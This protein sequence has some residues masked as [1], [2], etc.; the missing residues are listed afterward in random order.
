[1]Q[2]GKLILRSLRLGNNIKT[3]RYL[4]SPPRK[5]YGANH[6]PLSLAWNNKVPSTAKAFSAIILSALSVIN[7]H[8]DILFTIGPP[9]LLSG[10]YTYTRRDKHLFKKEISKILPNGKLA[11]EQSGRLYIKKYDESDVKNLKR[12]V[13]SVFDNFKVQILELAERRILD[14]ISSNLEEVK[15]KLP[16]IIDENDQITAKLGSDSIETFISLKVEILH[17][18]SDA[19]ELHS[20]IKLSVPLYLNQKLEKRHRIGV[21]EISLIEIGSPDQIDRLAYKYLIELSP[22]KWIVS[23]KDKIKIDDTDAE[24]PYESRFLLEDCN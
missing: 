12:N 16:Q 24:G 7:I 20:F 10:W 5:S 17:E 13:D 21:A 23:S 8:P 14:Y 19:K 15:G 18:M 4:S 3:S 2:H 6:T 1:M 22:Y 11:D 9:I